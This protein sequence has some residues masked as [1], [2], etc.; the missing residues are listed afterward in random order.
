MIDLI[1]PIRKHTFTPDIDL[2]DLIDDEAEFIA[3]H[4]F[5]WSKPNFQMVEEEDEPAR[6]APQSLVQRGQDS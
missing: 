1:P 2:Y 6:D 3:L 5:D 4:G